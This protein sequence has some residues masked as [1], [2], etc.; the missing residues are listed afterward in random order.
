MKIIAHRGFWKSE[1]AAQN[2]LNSALA[3]IREQFDGLEV[4]IRMSKDHILYL[5]HDPSHENFT[6][7]KTHSS[8]LD[9]LKLSS[10][11]HLARLSDFIEVV[12]TFPNLTL[13]LEIK[14]RRNKS[15]RKRITQ[16]LILQLKAHNLIQN[17]VLLSFDSR[18]LNYAYSIEPKLQRMVLVKNYNFNFYKIY[19]QKINAI[20]FEHQLI[21]KRPELIAQSKELGIETNAW[22]VNRPK[23]A[24]IIAELPITSI[25]TD[26]PNQILK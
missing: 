1:G 14:S 4:D 25:T 2:S 10:G 18:I 20:G 26:I 22:T 6:I 19:Y 23:R 17:S 24:K 7:H 5:N 11:E 21:L 13:Y 3:A 12:K 8:D 9:Q 16:E 15:Y